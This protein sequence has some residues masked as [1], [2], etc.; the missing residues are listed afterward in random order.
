ML[1]RWD[2]IKLVL[3]AAAKNSKN[4]VGIAHEKIF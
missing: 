2:A 1:C 3:A 4:A